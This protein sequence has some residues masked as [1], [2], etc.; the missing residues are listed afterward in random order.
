MVL[1]PIFFH[2]RKHLLTK[3]RLVGSCV[4][5]L[6]CVTKSFCVEISFFFCL[7]DPFKN[8]MSHRMTNDNKNHLNEKGEGS[9]ILLF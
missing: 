8:F 7:K 6:C 3:Q 2:S 4:N 1:L 5:K 9:I